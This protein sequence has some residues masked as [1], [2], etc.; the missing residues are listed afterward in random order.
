MDRNI[1]VLSTNGKA[2]RKDGKQITRKRY[3]ITNHRESNSSLICNGIHLDSNPCIYEYLK[4]WELKDSLCRIMSDELNETSKKILSE[5][6][7]KI[8]AHRRYDKDKL[9]IGEG[10][11]ELINE[12]DVVEKILTQKMRCI[13]C[14]KC[15]HVLYTN[16]YDPFQWSVDRIDNSLGHTKKNTVISCY[17]C[18]IRRRTRDMKEFYRDK[19]L[20]IEKLD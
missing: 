15:L 3:D 17:Q 7:S 19:N 13:Y 10:H 8:S 20:S 11:D 1:T 12:N 16:K 6:R 4:E 2:G 9:L 5:I 14:H 18:N